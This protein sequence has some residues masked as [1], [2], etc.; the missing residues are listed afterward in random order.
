MKLAI[1]YLNVIIPLTAII[2]LFLTLKTYSMEVD[3]LS[4]YLDMG[5]D[6]SNIIKTRIS[7]I[8][9]SR[10]NYDAH[11]HVIH[12]KKQLNTSYE[13]TMTFIGQHEFEAINDT[14]YVVVSNIETAYAVNEKLYKLF[15]TGLVRYVS[16][17]PSVDQLSI[18]IIPISKLKVEDKWDNWI[19]SISIN[20]LLSGQDRLKNTSF[21]GSISA[22]RIT[23]DL[24]ISVGFLNS[25]SESTIKLGVQEYFS[26]TRVNEFKSLIVKSI[27]NHWSYGFYLELLESTYMNYDISVDIAPAIEYNIFPYDQ[28]IHKEIRILYRMAYIFNNYRE[29]TIYDKEYEHLF[30]GNI[31]ATAEMKEKWGSLSLNLELKHYCH[32][33]NKYRAIIMS[34]LRY[35]LTNGL[36]LIL[37]ATASSIR[38]Q[39]ELP[40]G[41]AS[42]EEILLYRKQLET[43]YDYCF[44]I[45]FMFQFGSQ[46][47]NI[48]N[49]RFGLN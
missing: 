41:E 11:V 37:S 22:D 35:R 6:I 21:L 26:Y 47:K 8:N 44:S 5:P 3:S 4:V 12:A 14:L 43:Q 48:V 49:P 29:I 32:D 7:C 31:T 16:K 19:F 33:I 39:F 27:N 36:S 42:D 46:H 40:K 30:G 38:D 24:K 17:C 13:H 15:I 1:K 10:T 25:Y 34:Y 2:I 23:N 18:S 20:D 45:G 28:A 9:Y